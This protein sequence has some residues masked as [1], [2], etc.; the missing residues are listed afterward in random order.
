MILRMYVI[1][2]Q[3]VDHARRKAVRK[4]NLNGRLRPS[5]TVLGTAMQALVAAC[6]QF[7]CKSAQFPP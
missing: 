4:A 2:E 1:L 7:G 3:R 5:I 6:A